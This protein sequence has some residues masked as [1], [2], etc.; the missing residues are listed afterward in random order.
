M[1]SAFKL[2]EHPITLAVAYIC[3]TTSD[4][5][6]PCSQCLRGDKSAENHFTTETWRTP[7][8][9]KLGHYPAVLAIE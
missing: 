5:H 4:M 9:V 7:W 1:V 2:D 6:S 8:G 3:R